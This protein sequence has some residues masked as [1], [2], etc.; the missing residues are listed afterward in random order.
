MNDMRIAPGLLNPQP[1]SA[2]GRQQR[3]PDTEATRAFDRLLETA[4]RTAQ[5][6]PQR[7]PNRDTPRALPPE[8]V[9]VAERSPARVPDRTAAER[10]NTETGARSTARDKTVHE[11]H[12]GNRASQGGAKDLVRTPRGERSTGAT[13]TEQT[14][15]PTDG[16]SAQAALAK[17]TRADVDA[18]AQ[19]SLDPLQASPAQ[20]HASAQMLDALQLDALQLGSAALLQGTQGLTDAASAATDAASEAAAASKTD[21]ALELG[22]AT[23]GLTD[24]A[25]LAGKDVA[26]ESGPLALGAASEAQARVGV[27]DRLLEDF[28][29]RFEHSLAAMASRG[30]DGFSPGSPQALATL[31]AG[32]P[33]QQPIYS[34]A[35]ASIATPLNHS[36]FAQDF[37]QRVVLFAGQRVQNAELAIAP[38]DLGPIKV[39][40][41][42]RGQEASLAFT[43]QHATTRNAIEDALPRLREMFA[44]Q[45]LQLTHAHVG[46]QGRQDGGRHGHKG[47]QAAR[48]TSRLDHLSSIGAVGSQAPSRTHGARGVGL[49]DIHV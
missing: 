21:A 14:T 42:M 33:A 39:S 36:A 6:E 20:P 16:T 40:I 49:I 35:H 41:E 25:V 44:D 43:A 46:D 3:Q 34:S 19:P 12:Q 22:P 27:R 32:T 31:V 2:D 37:A 28:E 4:R 26:D 45:G 9:R 23:P 10:T 47:S 13:A 7:E 5:S 17:A 30:S 18:P 38:A 24:Q 8:A 29:R 1:P 11:S 48:D 15:Q